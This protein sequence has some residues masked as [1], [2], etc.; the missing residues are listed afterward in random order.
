MPIAW[1]ELR[2]DV[3]SDH[4]NLRNVP[5]RLKVDPWDDFFASQRTVTRAMMKRI[6]V[7]A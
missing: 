7:S 2:E 1:N 5:A 4:F 3:R 6:G